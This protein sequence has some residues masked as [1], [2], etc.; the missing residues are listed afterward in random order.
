MLNIAAFDCPAEFVYVASPLLTDYVYLQ[1]DITNTSD[2]I[3]LPGGASMFRNGEFVGRSEI[4][5]VTSGQ[6]FTAG[7]GIDSQIQVVRE[8]QDKKTDTLLGSRYNE[9]QYR[10]ALNNYKTVP[11]KLRLLD[12][13]PWTE[14]NSLAIELKSTSHPICEDAE[15]LRTERSKGLLRWDLELKAGAFGANAA[16][17]TYSYTMKYDKSMAVVPTEQNR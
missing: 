2:T 11:V 6:T 13:I 14:N 3:L 4:K 8:F 17:V 1:A 16:I 7:F 15:Y 10:I 9:Q 12:R 5:L